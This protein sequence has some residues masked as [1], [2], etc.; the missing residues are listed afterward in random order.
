MSLLAIPVLAYQSWGWALAQFGRPHAY[1][2]GQEA[3][4]EKM[5]GNFVGKL[6]KLQ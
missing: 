4:P 3:G 2:C 5:R 6:K 1:P